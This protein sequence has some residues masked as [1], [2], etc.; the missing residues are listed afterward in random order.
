MFGGHGHRRKDTN[1]GSRLAAVPRSRFLRHLTAGALAAIV[2]LAAAAPADANVRKLRHGVYAENPT[3]ADLDR[4]EDAGVKTLRVPL[5]WNT[6]ERRRSTTPAC[7][8]TIYRW[9]DFDR[10]AIES[11]QRGMRLLPVLGGSPG[12]ASKTGRSSNAPATGSGAF[13]DYECFVEAAVDRTGAGP[14]SGG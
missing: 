9:D 12:Y 10:L 8:P 6:I 5:R 4:M 13:R 7:D 14:P 1:R 3:T 11:S 2:A